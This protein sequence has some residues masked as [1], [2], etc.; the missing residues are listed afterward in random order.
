ME[1]ASDV[2]PTPLRLA[3]VAD[4]AGPDDYHLGDE[5]MLEANLSTLRQL[6]PQIR[7]T[8]FSR[9]PAAT[10]ARYK[11]DAIQTPRSQGELFADAIDAIRGASGLLVSGGGNLRELWPEK[12]AARVALIGLAR[13]LHKPVVIVG[14]TIGPELNPQQTALL[15]DVLPWAAWLGVRDDA[16]G[17]L[18]ETLGVPAARIHRQLDDAFFLESTPVDDSRIGNLEIDREPLIL[19]TL[20]AALGAPLGHGS[21]TAIAAQLDALAES[22]GGTI[23]FV[24]HVGGD[25]VEPSHDD[26]VTGR[27]IQRIMRSSIRLLDLWQPAEVKWLT[28]HA[29]M[30]I[31]SRYHPIVFATAACIPSLAIHQDEY[32]RIKLR[33]ALAPVGMENRCLALDDCASGAL[34]ATAVEEWHQRHGIQSRLVA[35]QRD[36]WRQEVARWQG[37][38]AALN[39]GHST[40]LPARPLDTPRA[41]TWQKGVRTMN[42]TLTEEQWSQFDR[43]GYL[44]LGRVVDD[45]Q[46]AALQQRVD[47]IMLGRVTYASVQ[48]QLDTGG[49][50]EDLP[51]PITGLHQPT[52]AYRKLQGLESDPLIL[53]LI[54]HDLFREA[55][56]RLYGRHA[57]I[58]IF[59][60]MLM[61]KPAGKGTHL[62]WHQDA[63]D[64]WKLDRDPILTSWI[65]LDPSTRANGCVEVIPGSHR[66]GLLSKNGSTVSDMHAAQHCPPDK[67]VFLEMGAGEAVILHNWMLHRSGVNTTA[68][69]RRALSA[70][71]MD[72]RT[73]NTLNGTRFPLVFGEP[74]D[75]E[76]AM[77]FMQPLNRNHRHLA[78]TAAEAERYA[79]SLE[80]EVSRLHSALADSA[81]SVQAAQLAAQPLGIRSAARSLVQAL[82]SRSRAATSRS[83]S[84]SS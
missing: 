4:V 6:A 28:E 47:D 26:R 2:A 24:P 8:V 74:E 32:T 55:S 60:A 43:D 34:L 21:L 12:L 66:L 52:L 40:P 48:S 10:R 75:L 71:Y 50:Y 54:R 7:F 67:I 69:P 33:G 80:Q 41:R 17:A 57:S 5:A 13:D 59:R 56:A 31:S 29:A 68:Q 18:A 38:C 44:L 73:L 72:G 64:V 58:S 76:T 39:V 79:R 53:D 3:V 9:D 62:P 49:R 42:R 77:P 78:E 46:L 25:A 11:V 16:S 37:I 82:K 1:A 27:A 15:S 81:R 35:I 84:R 45:E 51:D 70:C 83:S 20:D 23:V 14:Q 63:G 19:I 22:T 36:A 30:V 61:N 65:A